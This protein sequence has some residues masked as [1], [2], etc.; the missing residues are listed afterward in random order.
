MGVMH[1]LAEGGGELTASL[2]ENKLV[3][4]AL[5]FIAPKI[6]GGRDAVTSV[7]GEGVKK[8]RSAISLGNLNI[9]KFKKDILIRSEVA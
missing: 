3:D 4:E 9:T 6:V 1:V 7:E 8:M 2:F 5:F